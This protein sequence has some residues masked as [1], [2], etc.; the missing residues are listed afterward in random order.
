M[1][2]AMKESKSTSDSKMV[3]LVDS[4]KGNERFVVVPLSQKQRRKLGIVPYYRPFRLNK[5]FL[6]CPRLYLTVKRGLDILLSAAALAVL[7]PVI[8]V[9][10][11]AVVI[12][13][14][15][16]NPIFRQK[17]IGKDG[18]A[19]MMYKLRSMYTGA[20]KQL[21][22]IIDQNEVNGNAFKIK[23]D[24]R[25]T[26]VGRIARKYCIDEILQLLNVL[27]ADMSLVGP[28]PPLPQEVAQYD[29]FERQRLS[30]RPGLTCYWQVYPHRHEISFD[31]WV[32]MDLKYIISRSLKTDIQLILKTFSVIF[33]GNGD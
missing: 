22:F 20:E 24:P 10:M 16:G 8:L 25:I 32:A 14:P 13:D 4:P 7:W 30:I 11:L 2:T 23:N 33:S 12:E 21:S 19:F 27:K 26:R 9:F 6:S 3:D 28:R 1:N 18:R 15:H 17:R 5:E 29:E 31:D